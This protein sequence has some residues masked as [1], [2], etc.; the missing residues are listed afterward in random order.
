VVV[1]L[2]VEPDLVHVDGANTMHFFDSAP[3]PS[4]NLNGKGM[5]KRGADKSLRARRSDGPDRIRLRMEIRGVVQGV[6]FR[7]FVYRTAC[8]YLLAGKVYN[9]SCGVTIWVEGPRETVERFHT[10]LLVTAPPG[11]RIDSVETEEEA[12]VGEQG[13]R[14]VSSRETGDRAE[15]IPPELATC[16]DCL[17]EMFDPDDRRYGYPFINC[18]NCGPRFT[19]VK[20]IPYDR[21]A[22]TMA[23]F[24]MCADCER[25]YGD[26]ANRRFHAEPNACPKCG[27]QVWL[28]GGKGNR[29][30]EKSDAIDAAVEA[31][32]EGLTVAVKGLGGFHLACDAHD[33]DAVRALRER[34]QRHHKPFAVMV[35]DIEFLGKECYLSGYDRDLLESPERPIV[36]LR[37]R[38]ECAL[39]GEI[40]P[41]LE[42]AGVMLPYSPLHHLLLRRFGRAL[43][44]TSG[45]ISEEPI[46][47]RNSECPE[48]LAPLADRFLLH[49]REIHM[50]CD[51]SVARTDSDGPMILRR[52]RG[53]VPGTIALPWESE[54]EILACGAHLKNTFCLVREDRALL[55]HHIGDLENLEAFRSYEEGIAHFEGLFEVSPKVIVYD[56]HPEYFSTQYAQRR[57]AHARLGVQHHHAHLAACLAENGSAGPAIGV[58]FD[59]TGHGED[60]KIW[61]GEFLVGNLDGYLRVAHPEYMPLPGGDAAIQHPWQ[62]ALGYLWKTYGSGWRRHL[63]PGVSWPEE[64]CR[65]V[66]AMLAKGI[67]VHET[68]SM[69]RLFDAVACLA[70]GIQD[71]TYE[72]EAAI[73]LE[74]AAR[75]YMQETKLTRWHSDE[76][77]YPFRSDDGDPL[78][79]SVAFLIRAVVDHLRTGV[80]PAKVAYR[81]H[82][83]I[84]VLVREV[85]R[86]IRER[87]GVDEVALSGGTFQNCI[88]LEQCRDELRSRGF[89]VHTHHVVPPNDGGIAFGQAAIAAY[90]FGRKDSEHVSGCTCESFRDERLPSRGG[91]TRG[92]A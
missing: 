24:A 76:K 80:D 73:L 51:D 91:Y 37:R 15:V 9:H 84:V 13:F 60:G 55:S 83:S 29:L 33:A 31:L 68:S 10:D 74:M 56:L 23:E 14:I 90:R 5:K 49:N 19:I 38:D 87:M 34:K 88:L 44:M 53:Y 48:R 8:T 22:T 32:K 18:T 72:G 89:R 39:V 78:H 75:R 82:R 59:G 40:A 20:G 7:P 85:C 3:I 26:P 62:T 52:S 58:C 77:V 27:P 70:L 64:G 92:K 63:P 12:P 66:E 54:V 2:C 16:A 65:T 35:P 81:F 86:R 57:T 46:A 21:S 43:V 45:N 42:E 36:L 67:N 6:G 4:Y 25:E 61:G 28:E 47:Y 11:A 71:I 69:G 79:I 1:K 17:R 41:G 30:A 50:R